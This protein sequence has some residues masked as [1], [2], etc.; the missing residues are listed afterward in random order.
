MIKI[1]LQDGFSTVIDDADQLLVSGFAWRALRLPDHT[2]VQAWNRKQSLLMHRLIAGAGPKEQVDH[3]DG[4]GLNNVQLN[5]RIATGSQ[6]LANRGKPRWKH[7]LTSQFKGVSWDKNRERWIVF[8]KVGDKHRGLGRFI[9]EEEAARAY[10][11]AAF[12][13]WGRFA[14]LN[15]PVESAT[16]CS[17]HDLAISGAPCTC[18]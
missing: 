5:L 1:M 14:R 8:I 12:E 3:W 6:N 4:D 13:G 16:V 17:L 7:S 11:K 10:D 15:F 18:T 2:Y 9:D